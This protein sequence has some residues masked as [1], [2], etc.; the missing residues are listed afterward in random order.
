MPSTTTILRT[1]A[2]LGILSLA[3]ATATLPAQQPVNPATTGAATATGRRQ[4]ALRDQLRVGLKAVTKSD[5]EFLELVAQ[6]VDQGRLPRGLV[7]STFLWARSRS[8]SRPGR[9][10]L[11]PIVY[12]RPALTLRARRLGLV[13]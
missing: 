11:R 7:D 10:P 3:L 9:N 4:V 13:I 6:R 8:I 2:I 1:S 12:F 5:L